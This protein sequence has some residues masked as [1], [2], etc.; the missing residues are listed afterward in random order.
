MTALRNRQRTSITDREL[1]INNLNMDQ[2]RVGTEESL[3]DYD[4]GT[5]L[6]AT[7]PVGDTTKDTLLVKCKEVIEQ[8][9]REIEDEK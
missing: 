9:H 4:L 8:L 2:Q 1:I 3:D 7:Q 5:P 6:Y